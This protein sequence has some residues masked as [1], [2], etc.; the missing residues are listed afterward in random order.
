MK[1]KMY[2]AK[3]TAAYLRISVVSL[4]RLV[5][6]NQIRCTHIGRLYRFSEDQIAE[7]I[8]CGGGHTQN[9]KTKEAD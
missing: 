7:F 1:P 4:Y 2:N 5:Q 6:N 3:E 9:E 8:E